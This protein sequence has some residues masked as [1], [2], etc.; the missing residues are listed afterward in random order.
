MQIYNKVHAALL[1]SPLASQS[2]HDNRFVNLD[3]LDADWLKKQ[4]WLFLVLFELI[5]K[6]TFY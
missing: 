6:Q 5:M 3:S 2:V 4:R 1:N